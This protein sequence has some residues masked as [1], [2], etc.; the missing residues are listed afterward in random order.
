MRPDD[1]PPDWALPAWDATDTSP[2]AGAPR[3]ATA[4]ATRVGAD[5]C[6]AGTFGLR[7][8]N[9]CDVT[10]AVRDAVRSRPAAR[11]TS[12]SRARSA[13]S[14]S[15]A[16]GTPTSRSRTSAA[17]SNASGSATTGCVAV[18]A[19]DRAARRRPRPHRRVRGEGRLPA[20]RRV[21]PAGR[22][23]RPGAALRG[24]QG[25]ARRRRPVRPGAQAT[26]AG[27]AA[28]RS[29]SSRARR[30]PSGTTSGT[31]WPG[32][33]RWPRSSSSRARSRA[34]VRRRASSAALRRVDR[35]A[36]RRVARGPAA[37]RR[38]P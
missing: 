34:P 20:L 3:P 15:R 24:A 27:P 8:L 33:G 14:R 17:S 25:P 36:E 11:A 38:R 16:P 29:R 6:P 10:R 1:E 22:L 31:S 19:A 9:V 26:A 23:R 5:S 30:A 2:A 7:I 37:T 13:G 4:P 18:R 28:R 35:F 12:G 32:A 21:D